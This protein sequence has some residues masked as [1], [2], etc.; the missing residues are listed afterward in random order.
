MPNISVLKHKD[1][2]AKDD[3]E[4]KLPEKVKTQIEKKS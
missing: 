3:Y 4:R 2:Q 1:A